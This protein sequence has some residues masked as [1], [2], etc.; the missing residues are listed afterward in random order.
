MEE[1]LTFRP[2]SWFCLSFLAWL[3]LGQHRILNPLRPAGDRTQAARETSSITNPLCRSGDSRP[4]YQDYLTEFHLFRVAGTWKAACPWPL[5]SFPV[6]GVPLVSSPL[7]CTPG[8]PPG[9]SAVGRAPLN[10]LLKGRSGGGTMEGQ[11]CLTH[12]ASPEPALCARNTDQEANPAFA[13]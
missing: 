8:N 9:E 13:E 12:S 11:A 5:N 2:G 7:H 1:G 10:P 6:Q 4:G 3:Q